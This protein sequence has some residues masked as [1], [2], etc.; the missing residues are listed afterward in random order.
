MAVGSA[1]RANSLGLVGL[2]VAW[3]LLA[4][5]PANALEAFDGRIQAH[6]FVEMQVRAIS[7]KYGLNNDELDLA[8]WY[9]IL[10]VEFEFDVLPDGFGPIDLLSAF[11]RVEVRYDCI[12]TQGCEMFDSVNT[13]GNRHQRL[14][15]RLRN[16]QEP[17]YAGVIKVGEPVN[18]IQHQTAAKLQGLRET[19]YF[20]KQSGPLPEYPELVLAENDGIPLAPGTTPADDPSLIPLDDVPVRIDPN[21]PILRDGVHYSLDPANP[22]NDLKLDGVYF[23]PSLHRRLWNY[24][25]GVHPPSAGPA[26]AGLPVCDPALDCPGEAGGAIVAESNPIEHERIIEKLGFGFDTFFDLSGGDLIAN[27]A[28]DPGLYVFGEVADYRWGLKKVRGAAGGAGTTQFIGPWLPENTIH[29][30]AVLS[31]KANP[32]RGRVAPSVYT[33][34]GAPNR[35]FYTRSQDLAALPASNPLRDLL[36]AGDS[37]EDGYTDLVDPFP[38][39]LDHFWDTNYYSTAP[40]DNAFSYHAGLEQSEPEVRRRLQRHHPLRDAGASPAPARP[41]RQ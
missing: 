16:A 8:M 35:R 19:V 14:P 4:P 30:R 36:W 28:D 5:A 6:G 12:Y 23:T 27:T 24:P 13:F 21:G 31:H 37:P 3:L 18:K 11:V 22:D 17:D 10:N 1:Q 20:G 33:A 15:K 26:I 38:S 25:E 2:A 40:L 41:R 9:N 39:E 29:P 7:E 32:L 34:T